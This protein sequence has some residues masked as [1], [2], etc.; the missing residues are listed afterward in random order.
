FRRYRPIEGEPMSRTRFDSCLCRIFLFL[1]VIPT[2]ATAQN[3]LFTATSLNP[4]ASLPLAIATGDFNGDGF[5][6]EAVTSSGKNAVSILLGT[7]DG[8]FKPAVNYPVGADPVAIVAGD[9]NHDGHLDLAVLN[10][11]PNKSGVGGSISILMRV[12]DGTFVAGAT[13]AVG[14][15][16]TALAAGDFDGDG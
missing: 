5:T 7:G 12:G 13:Y 16:P 14:F 6:D 2:L 15:I 8:N 9:F 10:S 1:V 11:N 3:N 4:V